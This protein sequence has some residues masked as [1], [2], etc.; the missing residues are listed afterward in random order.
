MACSVPDVPSVFG[1]FYAT[2]KKRIMTKYIP[3]PFILKLLNEV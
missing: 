1:N 3:D 2:A